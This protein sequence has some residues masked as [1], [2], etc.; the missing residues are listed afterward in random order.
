[1]PKRSRKNGA[2]LLRAHLSEQRSELVENEEGTRLGR[3]PEY[4][5]RMRVATRRAR[6]ALR[7]GK[8]ADESEQVASLRS[9]LAWLG[10]VLGSVR[11]LDVFTGRLRAESETLERHE[12]SALKPVFSALA[13]ERRRARGAVTRALKGKRYQLLLDELGRV[14]EASP[15]R[16]GRL[17]LDR[18]ARRD[19]TG[20][21]RSMGALNGEPTDDE[22]HR[23]RILGK[24][25][26]YTAEL[27]AP[28]PSRAAAEFIKRAKSF[29]DVTGEHQDAVVAEA[30]L[31]ALASSAD[32]PASLA[33]G[34]LIERECERRR[35]A[36]SQLLE[37]WKKLE[38]AGAR[39]WS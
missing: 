30:K 9:E 26:R 6:A 35:A 28:N 5:H 39:A 12:R 22:V 37:A 1:M 16:K 14:V 31:R 15:S 33:V 23:V 38:Q 8:G 29:Q 32:G 21:A 34:R 36:R 2:E 18:R 24:R 4:L 17:D 11:D 7:A 10:G 27:A 20:L 25:A 19:F 3:D 13:A